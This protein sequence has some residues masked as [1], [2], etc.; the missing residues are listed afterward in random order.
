MDK[1]KL[2][3]KFTEIVAIRLH[4]F[5]QINKGVLPPESRTAGW[6]ER[7]LGTP[8]D[9]LPPYTVELNNFKLEVDN[10]V[11]MLMQAVTETQLNQV[12][13][14]R[15]ETIKEI[16]CNNIDDSNSLCKVE[17]DSLIVKAERAVQFICGYCMCNNCET[18]ILEPE[19][20]YGVACNS[21]I[22]ACLHCGRDNKVVE[23]A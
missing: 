13:D 22:I 3:N 21:D 12:K 11:I 2:F 18:S 20:L 7:Y 1:Q 6:R 10:F 8:Q 16:E 14:K 5:D 23:L 15:C 19:L 17:K 4:A 9:K